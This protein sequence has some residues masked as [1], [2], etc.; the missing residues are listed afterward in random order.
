MKEVTNSEWQEKLP[1]EGPGKRLKI[2]REAQELGRPKAAS[3]LHLDESKL[4]ALEKDDYEKLPGSVFVRGYLK[5]YARLLNVPADQILAQYDRIKPAEERKPNLYVSSIRDDIGSGHLMVR[6]MTWG[7]LIGLVAM[8]VIW[9]RTQFDWTLLSA[10]KD[11]SDD[12][13]AEV[14]ITERTGLASLPDLFDNQPVENNGETNLTL[15]PLTGNEDSLDLMQK[16]TTAPQPSSEDEK[17]AAL[18]TT[19]SGNILDT[20]TEEH[21][22]EEHHEVNPT[23]DSAEQPSSSGT[24]AGDIII[25][26]MD[27]CWVSIK[28]ASGTFKI[29]SIL[30]KGT[31]RVLKGEP[32]YKIVLG[33]AL[34]VRMTVNGE[35]YDLAPHTRGGVARLTLQPDS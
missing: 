34:A 26:I 31:Q 7:V 21:Q 5:N 22:T 30:K 13:I 18:P 15:P 3:L 28:D 6:L 17:I 10:T 25:E 4:E 11:E 33:K 32:P 12:I 9:W 29:H 35:E 20:R 1:P 19:T 2:L 27:D 24:T 23:V 8:I 14:D 16:D